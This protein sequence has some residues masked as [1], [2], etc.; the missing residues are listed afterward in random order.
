[1]TSRAEIESLIRDTVTRTGA[2]VI[3]I[4]STH[5]GG[6]LVTVRDRGGGDIR[7]DARDAVAA[8]LRAALPIWVGVELI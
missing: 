7:K 6:F 3:Q 5:P 2:V 8:K 4:A 1:M